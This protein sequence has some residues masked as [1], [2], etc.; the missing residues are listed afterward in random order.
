MSTYLPTKSVLTYPTPPRQ[1]L[2]PASWIVQHPF[3]SRSTG[4][5]FEYTV[6]MH[7]RNEPV[8]CMSVALTRRARTQRDHPSPLRKKAPHIFLVW[9]VLGR[10][11]AACVI[12]PGPDS[13]R[14]HYCM[15]RS[16]IAHTIKSEG[17]D[18]QQELKP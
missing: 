3:A 18:S 9:L 8:A 11:Y 14:E 6:D 15:S 4:T 12:P 1:A 17:K 13:H 7:I 5:T 10:L 16:E 2:H